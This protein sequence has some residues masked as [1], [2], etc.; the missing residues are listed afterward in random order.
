M[1]NKKM[2]YLF[3]TRYIGMLTIAFVLSAM[4]A[5]STAYAAYA[6]ASKIISPRMDQVLENNIG[7]RWQGLRGH[8]SYRVCVKE[9]GAT[10]CMVTK[11]VT[12]SSASF[13]VSSNLNALRGKRISL[14]VRACATRN[15][16]RCDRN[17]SQVNVY[18]KGRSVTV[19]SPAAGASYSRSDRKPT[20]S[21]QPYTGITYG[22]GSV[23]YE[24]SVW[25][26][27][28]AKQ[29]F[30]TTSTSFHLPTAI[31]AAFQNPVRWSVVAK[32]G[33]NQSQPSRARK[34]T[35]V[36]SSFT[37]VSAPSL[38]SPNNGA[39]VDTGSQLRWYAAA[40]AGSYKVCLGLYQ[41]GCNVMHTLGA[42]NTRYT[43]TS[44]DLKMFRN[45]TMYWGVQAIA[46]GGT[47]VAASVRRNVRVAQEH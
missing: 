47:S 15:G 30:T 34:L 11:I 36:A 45:K 23:S 19:T 1:K 25:G 32:K 10:Q 43:L 17:V 38:R 5:N 6:P 16:G 37:T 3:C 44:N 21:W 13:R 27:G 22:G 33:S 35:L 9:S 28:H 8:K 24:L 4:V 7:V 42:S 39:G 29:M 2:F 26:N 46:T 31:S 12:G 14:V 40:H 20:F 41:N 18:L